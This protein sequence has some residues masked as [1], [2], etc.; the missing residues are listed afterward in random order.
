MPLFI[1]VIILTSC[2]T[3]PTDVAMRER[4]SFVC[5]REFSTF[6]KAPGS[7][8][9]EAVLTSPE[10]KSRNHWN[11]LVVS[12]NA[13]PGA[14][15]KVEARAFYPDHTTKF[16]T[17]GLWS[18]QP[19]LHPRASVDGQKDRDGTVRTDT[20]ALLKPAMKAQIRVT[21]GDEHD[22]PVLKFL[23]LSFCDPRVPV[24]SL[25]PNRVAWGKALS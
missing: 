19:A 3:S 14:Y 21:I 6:A 22:H 12:W 13:S 16:Y 2:A 18:D 9:G 10:I 20:L 15:L 1:A 7:A 23:G 24:K 17:L 25:E 4:S 11:E 5:Y 8:P